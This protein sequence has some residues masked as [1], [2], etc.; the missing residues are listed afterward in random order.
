MPKVTQQVAEPE[1]PPRSPDLRIFA[2]NL[3]AELF[4]YP[5]PQQHTPVLPW[6]ACL[7][8]LL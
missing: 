1:L 5:Q 7:I 2:F 3:K 8:P 6:V 4:L